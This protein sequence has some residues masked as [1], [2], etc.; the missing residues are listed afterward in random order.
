MKKSLVKLLAVMLCL[1]S[2]L[3]LAACGEDAPAKADDDITPPAE[4]MNDPTED[5][6]T[7]DEP[8]Q[9]TEPETPD[10][11]NTTEIS[12]FWEVPTDPAV[13]PG[14]MIAYEGY[15]QAIAGDR[16]VYFPDT[17]ETMT[18]SEWLDRFS[19]DKDTDLVFSS[20]AVVNFD[21]YNNYD[22]IVIAIDDRETYGQ[23]V[24][25]Y[26]NDKVCAKYLSYNEMMFINNYGYWT[27][28]SISIEI[29]I[30]KFRDSLYWRDTY[31]FSLCLKGA[32]GYSAGLSYLQSINRHETTDV[33]EAEQE[34][35]FK[36]HLSEFYRIGEVKWL[37]FDEENI[38][39]Y[40]KLGDFKAQTPS[41]LQPETKINSSLKETEKWNTPEAKA[42]IAK[43]ERV[44]W[45]EENV[46]DAYTGK[47][48]LFFPDDERLRIV[49]EKYWITVVDMNLDGLP[50][51][52]VGYEDTNYGYDVL[53]SID[54]KIYRYGIFFRGAQEI[55]DDHIF[56]GSGGAATTYYTTYEL[57]ENG[58]IRNDIAY[59]DEYD[60]V[61]RINGNTVTKEELDAFVSSFGDA[62]SPNYNH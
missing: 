28:R 5:E 8:A 21:A 54:G 43:Y 33:D 3:V 44:I 12:A 30:K 39:K 41:E 55:Y 4:D 13:S 53:Y 10:E 25:Y 58:L 18:L 60:K 20:F 29:G 9:P 32:N 31:L 62:K 26:F 49:T 48:G 24:L 23:L 57:S 17:E 22:D 35:N 42:L 59:S 36:K 37:T 16:K 7:A 61:Y 47:E 52:L 15:Y 14:D 2:A 34:A 38:E 19:A 56:V 51:V 27:F 11:T 46:I 6:L 1:C 45:G 50:E 40:I